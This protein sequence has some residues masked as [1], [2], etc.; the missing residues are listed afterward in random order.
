MPKSRRSAKARRAT[1]ELER[2]RCRATSPRPRK[3]TL[4]AEW[5]RAGISASR[6]QPRSGAI[7]AS[8]LRRSSES[9]M[10][11]E[12]EQPA[13]VGDPERPVRPDP[14][15]RHDAVARDQEEVAVVCAEGP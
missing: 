5:K 14:V 12:T 10:A 1:A 15:R 6:Q 8:S 3:W 13:L 9:G 11:L 4:P 2:S 7:A